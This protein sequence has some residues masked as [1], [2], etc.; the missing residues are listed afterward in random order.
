MG[1]IIPNHNKSLLTRSRTQPE[2]LPCNCRNQ[3]PMNRTGE[4][5]LSNIVYKSTVSTDNND[6]LKKEYIGIS[7]TEF[8]LRYANHKQSFENIQKRDATSL[9]QYIWSLKESNIPFSVSW[10]I[11]ARCKSYA[12]GSKTCNLCLTE[13]LEILKC[14]PN[15]TLNKRTEIVG[16]CRHRAKFKLK[17]I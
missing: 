1:T 10:S 17:K 15:I 5:R 2:P 6:T 14:D 8:K 11:L 3:C 7:G 4:C 13:K 16:K 9:S 12:C